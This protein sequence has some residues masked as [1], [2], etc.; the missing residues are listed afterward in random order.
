MLEQA[1]PLR[2]RDFILWTAT[3]TDSFAL[4]FAAV[5]DLTTASKLIGITFY[6]QDSW[7][8]LFDG[9]VSGKS[10]CEPTFPS[11]WANIRAF[12]S[13]ARVSD[14][15]AGR[16]SVQ[17]VLQLIHTSQPIELAFAQT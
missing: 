16:C 17:L 3:C 15:L 2:P 6:M 12:S 8:D 4:Q 5:A 9:V 14:I 11:I 7:C 1:S 10:V 13:I